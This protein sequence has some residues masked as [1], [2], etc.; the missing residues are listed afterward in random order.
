MAQADDIVAIIEPQNPAERV[1]Q[2]FMGLIDA[3]FKTAAAVMIVPSCIARTVGPIVAVAGA[4]DD[5]SIWCALDI[6]SAAKEKLVVISPCRFDISV[7]LNERAK[8]TGVSIELVASKTEQFDLSA[9]FR[10]LGY[11]AERL[12]VMTRDAVDHADPSRI[13]SLR[14]VPVLVIEPTGGSV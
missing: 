7:E 1:T 2:Q 5:P 4:P 12:I 10:D 14:G 9:V 6:A 13:A 3:A 11:V 8:A